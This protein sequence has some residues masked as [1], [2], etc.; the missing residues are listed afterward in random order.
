[1]SFALLVAGAYAL[2]TL[3]RYSVAQTAT[4][5]TFALFLTLGLTPLS[6]APTGIDLAEMREEPWV[7]SC[8]APVT[9]NP[10][11]RHSL[12]RTL[13]D[14]HRQFRVAR[15]YFQTKND[16]AEIYSKVTKEL[17]TQY[18]LPWLPK[19]Q[20]EWYREKAWCLEKAQKAEVALPKL[21][22]TLQ[23]FA[24]TFHHLQS[25]ELDSHFNTNARE[26]RNKIIDAMYYDILRMLCEVETAIVILGIELPSSYKAAIVT[27]SPDWTEKGDF[28]R[29]LVQDSGVIQVY[30]VFLKDWIRA[31]R[32]L[33][34][35]AKDSET[36]D[37]SSLPPMETKKKRTK[38]G[39]KKNGRAQ[40][41][42]LQGKRPAPGRGQ[43]RGSRR[44]L[45]GNKQRKTE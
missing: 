22:D 34:A 9:D 2:A 28:T 41:P 43:G 37:P 40:R 18:S 25:F 4:I 19:N 38:Q 31:L 10:N 24:I 13:K 26:K 30:K 39:K 20:F 35:T 17:K 15:A 33:A 14:V 3:R 7:H 8:G 1:M 23:R 21:H 45:T 6:A 42:G 29:M 11:R 32:N 12:Y 5:T 16:I 36:C 44:K 27:E